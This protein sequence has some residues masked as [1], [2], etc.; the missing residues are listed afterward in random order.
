MIS[1]LSKYNYAVVWV[2]LKL[3][4]QTFRRISW[5]GIRLP[6]CKNMRNIVKYLLIFIKTVLGTRRDKF[7]T[8]RAMDFWRFLRNRFFIWWS[9]FYSPIFC[10]NRIIDIIGKILLAIRTMFWLYFERREILITMRTSE[11]RV[12]HRVQLFTE[13][14]LFPL[15]CSIVKSSETWWIV[16]IIVLV[17]GN[18]TIF[19][20]SFFELY[21]HQ[22][23]M[24][25]GITL[26]LISQLLKR[27]YE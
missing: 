27:F 4:V 14:L 22:V 8:K 17:L 6:I 13:I 20:F 21:D 24:H 3:E 26:S 12:S 7:I 23:S 1:F 19:I 16:E 2:H 25:M 15:E 9:I 5:D 10:G 11:T 18:I